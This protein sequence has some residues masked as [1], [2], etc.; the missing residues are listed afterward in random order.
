MPGLKLI[1]LMKGASGYLLTKWNEAHYRWY[2][3]TLMGIWFQSKVV[4]DSSQTPQSIWS[5]VFHCVVVQYIMTSS[6]GTFFRV[7]GHLCGEFTAHRCITSQR[8]SNADFSCFFDVGLHELLN[9]YSNGKR[10]ET[11]WHPCDVIVK[12]VNQVIRYA[13]IIF[14]SASIFQ[15]KE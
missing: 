11:T 7:A 9:K 5:K 10:F 13:S 15:Y 1:H 8:A 6:N 12:N 14:Y 3:A 2:D 4:Q